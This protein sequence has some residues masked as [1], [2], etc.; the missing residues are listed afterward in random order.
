MIDIDRVGGN[1]HQPL[2]PRHIREIDELATR[3]EGRQ[4]LGEAPAIFGEHSTLRGM[5]ANELVRRIGE[6][7]L[8]N[9]PAHRRKVCRNTAVSEAKTLL[10]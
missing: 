10:R 3:R 1:V 4:K 5:T 7:A 9:Q 2:E 8:V 6:E